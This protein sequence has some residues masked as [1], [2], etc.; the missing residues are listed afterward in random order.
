MR[1]CGIIF[2]LAAHYAMAIRHKIYCPCVKPMANLI[3]EK[4]LL[5]CFRGKG[6]MQ[7]VRFHTYL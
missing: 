4:M 3:E 7:L 5:V 6:S 2:L 1:E